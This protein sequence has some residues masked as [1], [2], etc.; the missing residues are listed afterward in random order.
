MKKFTATLTAIMLM[1][2][3]AMAAEGMPLTLNEAVELA[4]KNNRLIEQFEE[5]RQA[6]RWNLSAI[7]RSSGV[8]VTW[9]SSL[10]KI[11]GRYYHDLREQHDY[12]LG[13]PYEKL[14]PSYE[15][16]NSNTLSLTMP[17]YTGGQLENQ[18]ESA[19]YSLNSADLSLENSRQEVKYR[20]QAAYYQVLERAALIEVQKQALELLQEHL[21]TVEIQYEVGTV[22]KSDV[23]STSVQ[24]SNT[25]QSLTKAQGNYQTA[26]AQLNNILGL[27]VDTE[28]ATND[29]EDFKIYNLSEE[30]CLEY[31]L[32]HRP[33]GIAASYEVKRAEADTAAAK[34]NYR[35]NISAVVQGSIIG[36]GVFKAD[37]S[38]GRERWMAGVQLNWNVFDN[39]VTAAQVQQRKAAERKAESQARQQID[40]IHL[41]VK[42]A[43]IS[44]KTAEK[45]IE[46]TA[47]AV[48]KAEE[49]FAIAKVRYIEGVDTNLNVMNAQEK[50]VETRNNYYSALYSYNTS[51]AQLEKAMGVP[52]VIDAL[53]YSEAEQSGKNSTQSLSAAEVLKVKN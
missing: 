33:D 9:S 42:S 17:I 38:N 21:R 39:G 41:E 18:R 50:V 3:A 53:L 8:R 28:I 14:Y 6:A 30:E 23:L 20:A 46:T 36:E 19:R 4:L 22:A 47:A 1:T 10:N 15:N 7:R 52:V 26:V 35:P 11:G 32:K 2:K 25:Q 49:E 51:R 13:S 27:P 16:E 24:L 45:N 43:Y 40:S 12:Y 44:L 29:K 37:H 5:D 48:S 34:S 31:A